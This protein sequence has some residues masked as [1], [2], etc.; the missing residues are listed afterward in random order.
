MVFDFDIEFLSR[1]ALLSPQQFDDIEAES[2][3]TIPK[4][5]LR[6]LK[7]RHPKP[8]GIILL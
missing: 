3:L 4:A 7:T 8:L 1:G 5:S 6:I 2:C